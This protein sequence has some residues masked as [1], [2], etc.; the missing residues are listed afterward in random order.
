MLFTSRFPTRVPAAAPTASPD[1]V[2]DRLMLTGRVLDGDGRPV[3]GATVQVRSSD[4]TGAAHAGTAAIRTTTDDAGRYTIST[5]IP[6]PYQISP[7]GPTGWFIANEK[8]SPW[9]PAHLHATVRA[10][11]MCTA[12][13]RLYFRRDTWT[14]HDA[15]ESAILDPEPDADGI[16]RAVYDFALECREDRAGSES[17]PV[18][19]PVG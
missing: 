15:P 6:V 13:A 14:R 5:T 4:G 9:R 7:H 10:P 12:T 8:W 3:R 1:P 2:G 11:E 19:A 17:R 18:V 16:D